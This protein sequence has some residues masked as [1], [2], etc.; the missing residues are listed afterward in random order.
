M[1]KLPTTVPLES[2]IKHEI[3]WFLQLHRVFCWVNVSTG[4]YDQRAGKFRKLNGYGMRTGVPD[5]LGIFRGRPLAIEVKRPGQ[6]P[7][8][9]QAVFIKEFSEAGG[10]AFVATCIDDIKK[11][12]L[13]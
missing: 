11:N 3:I 5:I 6:K 8:Q 12:M 10:L 9:N 13:L 4:I 2:E 1:G 7:T